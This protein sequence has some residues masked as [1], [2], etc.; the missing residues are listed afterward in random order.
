[1][2]RFVPAL[3]AWLSVLLVPSTAV[4][5]EPSQTAPV[6]EGNSDVVYPEGAS[7]DADVLLELA[8]NQNGLKAARHDADDAI[9]AGFATL[10]WSGD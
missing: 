1:M 3:I 7:G 9:R 5:A 4:P 2:L 10:G 8:A 6:A